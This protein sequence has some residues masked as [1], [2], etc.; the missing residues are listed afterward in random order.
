LT[1]AGYK[2]ISI[3][4]LKVDAR[5]LHGK[6]VAVSGL[7]ILIDN[8]SAALLQSRQDSNPVGVLLGEAS[9]ETREQ[10]IGRCASSRG[11]QIE[12]KGTVIGDR[13]SVLIAAD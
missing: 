8:N 7:M 13:D 1:S 11:C 3:Q 2:P 9:R 5:A 12:I 4:Q 10:T 6:R